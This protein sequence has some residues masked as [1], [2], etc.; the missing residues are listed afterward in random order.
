MRN[1]SVADALN[2]GE[3]KYGMKDVLSGLKK[4]QDVICRYGETN[5]FVLPG[6]EP[7]AK[8]SMLYSN[9]RMG[10]LMKKYAEEMD[11]VIVD[12]P[13]CAVMNDAALIARNVEAGLLVIRRD[14]ARREKILT[15]AEI[16]AQSGN[17]LLGCVINGEEYGYSRY[18]Y[19][20]GK[21][22]YGRYGYGRYGYGKYG[23]GKAKNTEE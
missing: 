20:Y 11:F 13:P 1:P 19:G 23:Y 16:I 3:Q 21:Y 22:G 14:Y 18:G 9:S 4:A 8:V 12:T 7:L 6:G 10:L 15:G 2:L 5:L 17:T